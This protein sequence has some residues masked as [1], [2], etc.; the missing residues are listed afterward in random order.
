MTPT[1]RFRV[2]MFTKFLA[3]CLLLAGI[4][5]VGGT[6]VFKSE[7]ALKSRGTFLMKQLRRYQTFQERSAK[8]LTTATELAAGALALRQALAA[9]AAPVTDPAAPPAPAAPHLETRAIV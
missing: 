2:P 7:S 8:A 6:V 3:A 1:R 9:E 4:L 5:I